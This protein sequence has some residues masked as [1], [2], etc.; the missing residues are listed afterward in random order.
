MRERRRKVPQACFRHRSLAQPPANAPATARNGAW[1]APDAARPRS[2]SIPARRAWRDASANN[3]D[4]PTPASPAT[5]IEDP[6]PSRHPAAA[7]SS[8]ISSASRA[9]NTPGASSTRR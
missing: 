9:T 8:A 5:T 2:T 3:R 1:P 4:F 6:P 7:R